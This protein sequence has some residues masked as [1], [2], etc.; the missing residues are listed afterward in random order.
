MWL[1]KSFKKGINSFIEN[2]QYLIIAIVG[3]IIPI[4]VI[5]IISI[6]IIKYK[7]RHPKNKIRKN[8]KN[9]TKEENKKDV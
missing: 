7:K 1:F 2:L 5:I 4:C 9:L 6:F 3:H 8:I